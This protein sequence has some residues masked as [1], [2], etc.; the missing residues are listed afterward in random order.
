MTPALQQAIMAIHI[1]A[2]LVALLTGALAVAM[3]KGGS[4][5]ARAGTGFLAAMLVLGVTASILEPY[6]SPP[7]SPVGGVFVCYFV[8]TS[9]VTA[10]RRDGSTGWFETVAA[11]VALGTAALMAW[12]AIMGYASTPAGRGPI[13]ILAGLCLLAG[14]GDLKA[15]LLG[16]LTPTQRISRHLWR[17]LF[18]FF[19]ATGSFFLGQQDVMPAAVRGSPVLFVLAFAPFGVMLFWLLRIRVWKAVP[20]SRRPVALGATPLPEG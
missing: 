12:G 2:G 14:L 3:R 7:G 18:A 11:F 20:R 5:H 13:F 19:I 15:V 9:W 10:R 4:I 8:L 6:R 1:A 16:K 17:M